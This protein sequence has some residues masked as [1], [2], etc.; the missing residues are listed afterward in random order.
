MGIVF[1]V[2]VCFRLIE[3]ACFGQKQSEHRN[4]VA[5]YDVARYYDTIAAIPPYR[6]RNS[7]VRLAP[8]AG[9]FKSNLLAP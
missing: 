5:V 6:A 3:V 4:L 1:S 2:M 7:S 8:I 9:D